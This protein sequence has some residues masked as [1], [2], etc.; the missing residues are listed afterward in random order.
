M[1]ACIGIYMHVCVYVHVCVCVWVYVVIAKTCTIHEMRAF[2]L[3]LA[4]ASEQFGSVQDDHKIV[5]V[6]LFVS[7]THLELQ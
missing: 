5:V 2:P 6:R 7:C 3:M 1:F 4:C